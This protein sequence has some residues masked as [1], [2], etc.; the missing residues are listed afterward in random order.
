MVVVLAGLGVGWILS[1]PQGAPD[2][3]TVGAPAP[4]IDVPLLDG[5]GRFVLSEELAAHDKT[6]VVN[7]WAS[8]CGPC[9]FETPD[10]SAFAQANP[11]VKVVGVA[12]EDTEQAAIEFADEFRPAYELAFG[13]DDFD[14][15]Y[16]RLGLPATYVIGPDGVVDHLFN[17]I[18]NEEVLTGLTGG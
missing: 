8:W 10:I 15:A 18:V 11:D 17:G 4:D 7:L 3:A 5:T 2:S 14:A 1:S 16:P 12:V 9:R 6:I 13:N